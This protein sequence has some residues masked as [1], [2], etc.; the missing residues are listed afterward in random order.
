M[1]QEANFN[2]SSV[3]QLKS[4]RAEITEGKVRSPARFLSRLAACHLL[5]AVGEPLGDDHVYSIVACTLVQELATYQSHMSLSKALS[6]SKSVSSSKC[7]S[8]WSEY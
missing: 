8:A 4:V 3:I 7:S 1:L 2:L 5:T 6:L